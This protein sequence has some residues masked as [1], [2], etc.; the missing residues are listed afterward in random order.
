MFKVKSQLTNVRPSKSEVPE[1]TTS[2]SDG[3]L[4]INAPAAKLLGVTIKD[5]LTVVDAE[6]E[7][8]AAYFLSVGQKGNDG[9]DGSPKQNQIGGIL[10]S[11]TGAAGGSLA[12]GSQNAWNAL[13]G[14]EDIKKIYT[15][16]E[17]PVEFEGKQY[18][19]LTFSNDEPKTIRKPRAE[20]QA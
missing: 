7:S 1:L 19:K 10:S 6:D 14:N 11:T 15:I 4:K 8:G 5:Y 12:F 18:Y 16:S 3:Q 17:T 13:K 9:K 20:K 2:P